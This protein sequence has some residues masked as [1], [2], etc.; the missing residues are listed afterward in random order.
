GSSARYPMAVVPDI[1]PP[2]TRQAVVQ[3]GL[4]PSAYGHRRARDCFLIDSSIEKRLRDATGHPM[5]QRAPPLRGRLWHSPAR[6]LL[7]GRALESRFRARRHVTARAYVPS[8]P[9]VAAPLA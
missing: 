1:G 5:M 4:G 3:P 6:P 2:T 9:E 7:A 8:A